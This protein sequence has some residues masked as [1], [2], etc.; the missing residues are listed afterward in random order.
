MSACDPKRTLP[1]SVTPA[2]HRRQTHSERR[3]EPSLWDLYAIRSPW[4]A[5][6]A[7]G[8]G[9]PLSYDSD[10]RGIRHE[11][12]NQLPEVILERPKRCKA[13]QGRH[14]AALNLKMTSSPHFPN[15]PSRVPGSL[16]QNM[17]AT[18]TA[19]RWPSSLCLPAAIALSLVLAAAGAKAQDLESCSKSE[20]A[21][22]AGNY[23]LAVDYYTRCIDAGGLTREDLANTHSNR[24][25]AHYHN[26][27]YDQA[28]L[29]FD[30]ALALD[31]GDAEVYYNRG[32]AYRNKGDYDQAVRDYGEAI[33]LDPEFAFAYKSRGIAH[34]KMGNY[35]L[36]I[37]DYDRAIALDSGDADAYYNRG[38]AY[39]HKGDYGRAIQNYDQAFAF[40]PE[41]AEIY[42]NRGLAYRHKQDYGQAVRDYDAAIRLNSEFAFAYNNRGI[43]HYQ[44]AAYDQAV[45]DYDEA[46]LID[47]DFASAY[48][49]RGKVRSKMGHN[50]QAVQDYGDA[51]RLNSVIST[52]FFD[53]TE[54]IRDYP[55]ITD[56]PSATAL[57][58]ATRR[59][60]S[61]AMSSPPTTQELELAP[62]GSPEAD[63]RSF[64]VQLASVRTEGDAEFEW[65][66][67]QRRFSDLLARRDLVVQT[68]DLETRG[69]FF[70]V[71]TGPFENR[72]EAQD[73][74]AEFK[75]REKDCLAVRL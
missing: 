64:A 31:P 5:E 75:F 10:M 27:M 72:T 20:I 23:V 15:G 47:P 25:V 36:A 53:Y 51:V 2:P 59:N 33:R 18:N 6:S 39:Y 29:D 69:I 38:L 41:K 11:R 66:R 22:E 45:R 17:F 32:L 65:K 49:N 1:Q 73:L 7:I 4:P 58:T 56:A 42:N 62:A 19:R 24:G 48:Y 13:M 28:I 61:T 46:I 37:E 16:N 71:L 30:A 9:I 43:A 21:Q 74:C 26:G 14:F 50:V 12:D 68:V 63:S 40:G 70:R 55:K 3:L 60:G 67:L 57:V 52:A 8:F 34:R 54:A 35:D 44:N